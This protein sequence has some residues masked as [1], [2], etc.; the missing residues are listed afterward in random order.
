MT[1]PHPPAIEASLSTE[2]P[3]APAILSGLRRARISVVVVGSVW[4][5]FAWRAF[6]AL[7]LWHV[8]VAGEV[9]TWLAWALFVGVV[10]TLLALFRFFVALGT[11]ERDPTPARL[12]RALMYQGAFWACLVFVIGPVGALIALARFL[13][14]P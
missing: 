8:L 6:N 14:T 1:D 3:V 13:W 11:L 10:L 7:T 9:R 5:Y 12:E 4:L 2:A